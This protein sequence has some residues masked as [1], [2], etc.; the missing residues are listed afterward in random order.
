MP[1]T[2]GPRTTG[3]VGAAPMAITSVPAYAQAT[4]PAMQ[5]V[6]AQPQTPAALKPY[7]VG[8]LFY[9]R[10]HIGAAHTLSYSVYYDAVDLL[11]ARPECQHTNTHFPPGGLC[12]H[13]RAP[14]DTVLIHE[15]R[16]ANGGIAP[17]MIRALLPL[18][19]ANHPRILHHRSI[20]RLELAVYTVVHHPGQ[21]LPLV[22]SQRPYASDDAV[23]VVAQM[24]R[25]LT[26]LHQQGFAYTNGANDVS[27]EGLES[28]VVLN[29]GDV[30][31]ADLS[32]CWPLSQQDAGRAQIARD[33]AFLGQSL[34]F[35]T[36]DPQQPMAGD[37]AQVPQELRMC[38]ERA[39]AGQYASV[40][41]MFND[42]AVMA[43]S[44]TAGRM[45]KPSE[46][47]ATHQGRRHTRNED[48]IVTFTFDKKQ[49]GKSVPIGFYM[50]AD[51][52]GGH[53]AGDVA[54]HTVYEVVTKWIV[55]TNILP[56]LRKTTR[57]LTTENVPGQL[58]EK[59]IQSAN[60]ALVRH[61]QAHDSNLGSTVTA[62]LVIGDV[63]TIAN[64]GDSRTY[65]LRKGQ[66][67]QITQDHSL[68]ARLVEANVIAPEEVRE[69]PRRNQIYR[70]LGQKSAV[71]VDIFTVHLQPDDR[72][73]LCCDGL[74]EMVPDAEIQRLVE[75]SRTPQ[76]ACD[77]LIAAANQA[78]G[79]DNISVIVVEME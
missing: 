29:G 4:Q 30:K 69:H 13:C 56:D 41:E 60:E 1:S 20:L 27:R 31:L 26:Y 59:A 6:P 16:T 58:L 66:L 51:G 21:W 18:G 7:G 75:T 70:N 65:L 25:A 64:V 8:E 79:E 68:V 35:L 78:G 15:R 24:G 36:H 67:R 55:E 34:V 37:L 42:L 9:N 28:W 52:M 63:A 10:Y 74:W 71:Q 54:S 49:Q 39:K 19:R 45:L 43:E 22:Q 53:D 14:L 2:S 33:I 62:A 73:I 12:A 23:A 5:P 47:H 46:G 61:A 76:K 32:R 48:M 72:L 38:I 50:V 44:P 77:A 17:E 40:V 11:C 3:A 57:K